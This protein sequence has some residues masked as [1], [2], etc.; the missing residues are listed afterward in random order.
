MK[1]KLANGHSD[2]LYPQV[3][4]WCSTHA[5]K[6]EV[7]SHHGSLP[8]T[9][10]MTD[11]SIIVPRVTRLNGVQRLYTDRTMLSKT[12]PSAT[13]TRQKNSLPPP[14]TSRLFRRRWEGLNVGADN[15]PQK[16]SAFYGRAGGANGIQEVNKHSSSKELRKTRICFQSQ[17]K[18]RY[19]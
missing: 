3:C 14:E 16:P 5:L 15:L 17:P 8:Y 1:S 11:I 18:K 2:S 13:K 19:R 10:W 4:V 7:V 6:F 9:W 12:N